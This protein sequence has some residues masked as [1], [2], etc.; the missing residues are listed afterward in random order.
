MCSGLDLPTEVDT[1]LQ[2]EHVPEGQDL[3]KVPVELG[4]T[5][6]Q[7]LVVTNDVQELGDVAEQPSVEMLEGVLPRHLFFNRC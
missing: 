4:T 6:L 1:G 5:E 2:P 3:N 7:Q